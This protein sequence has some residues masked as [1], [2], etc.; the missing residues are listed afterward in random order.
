MVNEFR[1]DAGFGFKIS[2]GWAPNKETEGLLHVDGRPVGFGPV[3]ALGG[4]LDPWV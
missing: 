1:A 2:V 4:V 3:G